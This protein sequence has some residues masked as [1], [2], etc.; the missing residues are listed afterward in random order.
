MATDRSG[1]LVYFRNIDVA[2]AISPYQKAYI[3]KR[4]L[5]T[6][7]AIVGS[8][9]IAAAADLPTSKGAPVAPVRY[10]PVFTWTGFYLG[11]NAGVGWGSSRSII[12]TGPTAASGGVVSAGNNGQ[13]VGGGQAG[14]NYQ[15]GAWVFGVETD[16]QYVS[17]NKRASWGQ[18]TWWGNTGSNNGGYLGT[19]RGRVG[20]AFDRTLIYL[21]GGLAYGGLNSNPITGNTTSN[22]GWTIGAGLEYAFTQNWT[23][24]IEGLYL[25]NS[26]GNS[27]RVYNNPVGGVL[28]AGT[29]TAVATSSNGGGLVRAGFNYKFDTGGSSVVAKY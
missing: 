27:S 6:C 13:F 28:P 1:Q 26:T 17:T 18:Y 9:G 22:V 8:M 4:I 23:A 12:I 21:T 16:I 25:S 7:T 2:K 3:M 24:K 11:L 29:Y 19:V 10:A 20:Y 15:T 5:L 14:Y